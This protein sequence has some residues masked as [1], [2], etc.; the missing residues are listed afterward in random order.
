M[1][2]QV[3][4]VD[5]HRL[6]LAVPGS[7]S[8]HHPREDALVAP[9]LPAVVERLVRPVF[10]RRVSPAQPITIDEDNPTQDAPIIDARLAWDFGK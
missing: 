10:L 9:A 1:G 5:H 7:Q 6:L 2:L 8:G 3:G 4:G